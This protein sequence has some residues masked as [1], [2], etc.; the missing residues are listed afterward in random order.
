MKG[1]NLTI[2]LDIG[3]HAVK[4]CE[5]KETKWDFVVLQDRGGR[6]RSNPGATLADARNF[7]KIIKEAGAQ[8]LLYVT[9]VY[10]DKI[11][12]QDKT[13]RGCQKI[14]GELNAK[15]V[16]VG[17]AIHEVYARA[18]GTELHMTDRVHPNAECHRLIAEAIDEV[19][20]AL[21]TSDRE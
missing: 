2:G 7:D 15:I 3:S 14:A 10:R 16:P 20:S 11:A 12:D 4:I 8:T 1:Q 19:V 21:T 9:P 13:L 5:L 6:V 18:P 17:P